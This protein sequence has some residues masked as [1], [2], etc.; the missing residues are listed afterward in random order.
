[1]R[2]LIEV[3]L[4][5]EDESFYNIVQRGDQ[6]TYLFQ[7]HS[8][9]SEPHSLNLLKEPRIPFIVGKTDPR[10]RKWSIG[11]TQ[12]SCQSCHESR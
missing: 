8:V 3:I 11:Q 1:M 4:L 10:Y 2:A 9:P 6:H 5:M 7:R 12:A